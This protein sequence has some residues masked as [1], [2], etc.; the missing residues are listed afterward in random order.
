MLQGFSSA[1]DTVFLVGG[2]TT[3]VAFALVWFLREVP[4]STKSGLQR[5]A[6]GEDAEERPLI[7]V[8]D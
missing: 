5:A 3:V 2:I 4:L 1:M 6:D 8:M 7:P